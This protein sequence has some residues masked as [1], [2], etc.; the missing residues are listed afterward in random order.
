M[1]GLNGQNKQ[2]IVRDWILKS[3]LKIVGLLETK[4]QLEKFSG[5]VSGLNMQAWNFIS[6]GTEGTA[7]IIIGWD[8]RECEVNCIHVRQQWMTCNIQYINC[9]VHFTVSFIYG[10]NTPAERQDLWAYLISQSNAM[11]DQA[12]LLM[13]DFN[14]TIKAADSYGGDTR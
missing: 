14:A 6:N 9:N 3:K 8:S 12:W 2:K 13:G 7:R 5:V 11:G 10:L 4:I 1:R